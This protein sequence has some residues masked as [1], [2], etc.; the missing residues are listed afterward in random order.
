MLLWT[1]G[2]FSARHKID[3]ECVPT[4]NDA[5]LSHDFVFHTVL[6]I[7]GVKSPS[8]RPDLDLLAGCRQSLANKT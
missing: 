7:F 5:P 4:A 2:T 6:A 3:A 8:Y 1:D